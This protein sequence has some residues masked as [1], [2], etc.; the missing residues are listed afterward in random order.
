MRKA[1]EVRTVFAVDRTPRR[2]KARQCDYARRRLKLRMPSHGR[3][4][5]EIGFFR[6]ALVTGFIVEACRIK[7]NLNL[8]RIKGQRVQKALHR[9]GRFA[10]QRPLRALPGYI[11]LCFCVIFSIQPAYRSM[12]MRRTLRRLLDK[13]GQT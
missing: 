2:P 1:S 6:S 10:L 12:G 9:L 11:E 5:L 13:F 8:P 4:R 3:E 7:P